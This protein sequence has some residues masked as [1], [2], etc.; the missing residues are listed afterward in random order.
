MYWNCDSF[1][2]TLWLCTTSTTRSLLHVHSQAIHFLPLKLSLPCLLPLSALLLP[3]FRILP[4]THY[5]YLLTF[6]LLTSYINFAE[7]NFGNCRFQRHQNVSNF[8]IIIFSSFPPTYFSTRVF[9][10]IAISC[11]NSVIIFKFIRLVFLYC[12]KT[13]IYIVVLFYCSFF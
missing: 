2:C 3:I 5:L 13:I 6:P 7:G 10:K 9:F 12:L 1:D 4:I 11:Q 8:I